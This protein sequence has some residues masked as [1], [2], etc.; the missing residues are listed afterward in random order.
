MS[1]ADRGSERRLVSAG[2]WRT[3]LEGLPAVALPAGLTVHVAAGPFAR[4]RGLAALDD[5]PGERGLLLPRTRSVHTLGMRFA[6]DLV[7]LGRDGRVVEVEEDVAPRR[8]VMCRAARSVVEV[9]AGWGARF[10]EG[11]LEAALRR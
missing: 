10:V 3:R 11:G 4:L 8:H 9:R 5:L 2:A 7:W 1:D 6:L